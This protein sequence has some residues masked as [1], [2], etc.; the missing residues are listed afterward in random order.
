MALGMGVN[1]KEVNLVVHYG[2][3]HSIADYF[4]ESGRGGR[5]W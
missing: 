3:L 4:Q 5:K 2:A 1:I